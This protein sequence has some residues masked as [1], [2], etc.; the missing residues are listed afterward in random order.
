M[1]HALSVKSR[2][3]DTRAV[4]PAPGPLSARHHRVVVL[5]EAIVVL[6]V[7][8]LKPRP[9]VGILLARHEQ[10]RRRTEHR[11]RALARVGERRD[12][13]LACSRPGSGLGLR[14]ASWGSQAACGRGVRAR[15][16]GVA[17]GRGAARGAPPHS[18]LPSTCCVYEAMSLPSAAMYG[19]KSA[20]CERMYAAARRRQAE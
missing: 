15:R 17:C 8:Q 12:L 16:A 1:A 10:R 7:A 13:E 9:V 19:R 5:A 14:V 18:L 11:D 4:R 3:E 2:T 20:G 6:V